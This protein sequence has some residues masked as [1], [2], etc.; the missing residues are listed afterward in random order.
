MNVS[1]LALRTFDLGLWGHGRAG[2]RA[3]KPPS[4][5]VSENVYMFY[6]FCFPQRVRVWLLSRSRRR[7]RPGVAGAGGRA[8]EQAGG[9]ASGR[10]AGERGGLGAKAGVGTR[11]NVTAAVATKAAPRKRGRRRGLGRGRSLRRRRRDSG[12]QGKGGQGAGKPKAGGLGDQ[13]AG[14]WG[15]K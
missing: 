2:G 3:P 8:G 5:K 6:D 15:R 9:R 12:R 13:R 4:V 10:Q 1:K 11:T 7:R 14:S